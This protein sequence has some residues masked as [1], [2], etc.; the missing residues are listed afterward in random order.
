MILAPR[1]SARKRNLL[2]K[3][4]AEDMI[5][6]AKYGACA[7]KVARVNRNTANLWY[8]HFREAIYR[9]QRMAPRLFGEVEMDQKAFGGRGRK[10]M[11]AYLKRLAKTLPHAE[12]LAKAKE[13]RKEHKVQVFGVLQRGGVVY[14]HVLKKAD[15]VTLQSIV[16][17]VVEQGAT[18]YT[19]AWRGFSELGID[20]YT[21]HSVNHSI[22]YT[23]RKGN[24]INGIESFWSF[25]A[26]RLA[27][28]NGISSHMLPLH[29]KECEF[30]FNNR[31]MLKRMKGLLK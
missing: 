10:R 7:A 13:I 18:V 5:A 14:C 25:A 16:R 24:H 23:D 1:I 27:K 22:E 31:D 15:K 29:V 17:L 12:Y 3:C 26:R 21:H 2:L 19:D 9:S 8:R 28:F 20:G 4:F 6:Y 30:R 11:Q